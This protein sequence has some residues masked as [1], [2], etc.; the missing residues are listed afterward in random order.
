V[1]FDDVYQMEISGREIKTIAEMNYNDYKPDGCTALL[2]AIGI[3]TKNF[4]KRFAEMDESKRPEK[5]IIAILTDGEENSSVEYTAS[6]IKEMISEQEDKYG[7]TYMFLSS[8]LSSL[9]NAQKFYGFS[10]QNTA[11]YSQDAKSYQGS[12][13]VYHSMSKTIRNRVDGD[14][15]SEIKVT[16]T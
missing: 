4:G 13:S 12:N 9:K 5:V 15:D 2:D 16:K 11:L 7:W 14:S 3:T 1:L 8:D 10:M 6:A